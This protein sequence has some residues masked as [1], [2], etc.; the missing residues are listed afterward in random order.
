MY[1]HFIFLYIVAYSPAI[2]SFTLDLFILVVD[3]DTLSTVN[4]ATG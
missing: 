2:L 3:I 1:V 4:V